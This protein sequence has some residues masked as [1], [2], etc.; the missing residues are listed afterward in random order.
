LTIAENNALKI[1][2]TNA[3]YGGKCGQNKLGMRRD[4]NSGKNRVGKKMF[5]CLVSRPTRW[6]RKSLK[7]FLHQSHKVF[8]ANHVIRRIYPFGKERRFPR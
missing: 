8:D 1:L 5:E 7:Y 6:K 2:D 4:M 3:G